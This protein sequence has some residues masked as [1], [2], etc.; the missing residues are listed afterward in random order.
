MKYF[1]CYFDFSYNRLVYLRGIGSRRMNITPSNYP[2][3][4]TYKFWGDGNIIT[5]AFMFALPLWFLPHG[6]GAFRQTAA[7]CGGGT[8]HPHH[9]SFAHLY[10]TAE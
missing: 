9:R 7:L 10:A 3:Y 4:T 5:L 2:Y 1:G 6:E 8:G